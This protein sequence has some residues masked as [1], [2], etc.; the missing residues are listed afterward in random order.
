MVVITV[1]VKAAM[2]TGITDITV[3][4]AVHTV[5]W[6]LVYVDDDV[7]LACLV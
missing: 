7:T 4:I 6:K 5:V 2:V 3:A 1:F